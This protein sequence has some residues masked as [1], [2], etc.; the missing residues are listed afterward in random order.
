MGPQDISITALIFTFLLLVIPLSIMYY[1]RL[2]LIRNTLISV[3][4]MAV[5]LFLMG[6]YLKYLLEWNIPWLNAVWVGVMVIVASF[7][8][9]R[10]AELNRRY[11]FWPVTGS[12]IFSVVS[13][14]LYF[15]RVI[16]GLDN[17]LD[18][19]YFIVIGGMFLGNSLRGNIIGVSGFFREL[20][21][22]QERYLY[23]LAMGATVLEGVTPYLRSA[24]N[25]ALKPSLAATATMGI[26]FLPGMMTGQI[27]GGATP[28][29]AIKYQIAI[30]IAIFVILG[31]AV[32][33][34]I[35]LTLR[36]SFDAYGVMRGDVFRSSREK[37]NVRSPRKPGK[38]LQES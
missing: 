15:N 11:F 27:L 14:L 28:V 18:A 2:G 24:L 38:R 9:I 5:Q 31:I 26:V 33:L 16:L 10:N 17:I 37:K 25:A 4:R 34:A 7:T 35:L 19:K 32:T 12:L 36:A 6:I 23:R 22:N 21:R 30:M 1:F 3:G 13:I 8:V 20:Q 29:T